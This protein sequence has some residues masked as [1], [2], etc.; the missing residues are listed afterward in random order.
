M[1]T[2]TQR[3]PV[4]QGLTSTVLLPELDRVWLILGRLLRVLPV[5][6]ALGGAWQILMHSKGLSGTMLL[7]LVTIEGAAGLQH[8]QTHTSDG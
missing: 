5:V 8:R 7:A 6:M 4:W 1:S 2:Q 3:K